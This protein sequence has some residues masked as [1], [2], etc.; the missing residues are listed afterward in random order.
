MVK[1]QCLGGALLLLVATGT[2]EA[3]TNDLQQM[4]SSCFWKLLSQS[5]SIDEDTGAAI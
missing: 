2:T 4:G 5:I 3:L 1:L